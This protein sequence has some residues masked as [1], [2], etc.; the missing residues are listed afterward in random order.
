MALVQPAHLLIHDPDV[1]A[2]AESETD[3]AS[4]HGHDAD[5]YPGPHLCSMPP[6]MHEPHGSPVARLTA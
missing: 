5:Q 4:E 3:A 1:P 6:V 2:D